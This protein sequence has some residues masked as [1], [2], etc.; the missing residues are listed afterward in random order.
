MIK[1]NNKLSPKMR[2]LR[3]KILSKYFVNN[4]NNYNHQ[5]VEKTNKSELKKKSNFCK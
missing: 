3:W 4:K 5:L 1:E 2:Y